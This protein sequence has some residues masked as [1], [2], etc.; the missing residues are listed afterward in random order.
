MC[1]CG[2]DHMPGEP[3]APTGLFDNKVKSESIFSWPDPKKPGKTHGKDMM[4]ICKRWYDRDKYLTTKDALERY[5]QEKYLLGDPLEENHLSF[6]FINTVLLKPAIQELLNERFKYLFIEWIFTNTVFEAIN[7]TD[8]TYDEMLYHKMTGFLSQLR[9][10][11]DHSNIVVV[12]TD[13]YWLTDENGKDIIK[14]SARIL[15]EPIIR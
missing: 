2:Y 10:F 5:Y 9:H 15:A 4:L 14:D 3:G 6:G 7:R 13:G 8:V 11:E 1:I 12:N